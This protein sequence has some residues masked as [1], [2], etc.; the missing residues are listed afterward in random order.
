[1]VQSGRIVTTDSRLRDIG[2]EKREFEQPLHCR[3]EVAEYIERAW[4]QRSWRNHVEHHQHVG[5]GADCKDRNCEPQIATSRHARQA[6]IVA[7]LQV[8]NGKGKTG[9]DKEQTDGKRTVHEKTLRPEEPIR[10]EAVGRQAVDKY[11]VKQ[12]D[13]GSPATQSVQESE[14]RRALVGRHSPIVRSSDFGRSRRCATR[15][16]LLVPA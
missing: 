7:T 15:R 3:R 12:D 13:D 16:S 6:P 9:N 14:T 2:G 8:A 11:V 1:M 5:D 4:S 10:H